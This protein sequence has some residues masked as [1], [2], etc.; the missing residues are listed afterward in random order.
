MDK[1]FYAQID[2]YTEKA[3]SITDKYN[4]IIAKMQGYRNFTNTN[5][6]YA[7][8]FTEIFKDKELANIWLNLLKTDANYTHA[9]TL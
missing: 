3:S 1:Q 9:N 6:V 5:E 7:I 8:I 2:A 4:D